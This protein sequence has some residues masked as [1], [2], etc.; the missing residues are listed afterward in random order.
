MCLSAA[1]TWRLRI[2]RSAMCF[3]CRWCESDGDGSPSGAKAAAVRSEKATSSASVVWASALMTPPCTRVHSSLVAQAWPWSST[4]EHS[5]RPSWRVV[6]EAAHRRDGALERED[7][8]VH[9]DRLRGTRQAVAAVR[10]AGALDEGG[11][12]EQRD[13]ALEVGERQALGLGD[14]LE[15]DR[16]PGA[17]PAEL[18][19]QAHSVLRLRREDHDAQSYQR[20]R[21]SPEGRRAPQGVSC[22]AQIWKDARVRADEGV[23]REGPVPP[24]MARHRTLCIV[25]ATVACSLVPAATASACAGSRSRPSP[26]SLERADSRDRVPDQP[27]ARQNGLGA[28]RT[29]GALARPRRPQPRHGPHDFFAHDSPTGSTPK[30]RIDRAGYFDGAA[31]WAMGETIAWGSGGRATPGGDRALVAALARAPGDPARRPLPRPR[32]RHRA[33]G[34]GQAAARRSPGTSARA[35]RRCRHPRAAM[36]RRDGALRGPRRTHRARDG[37]GAGALSRRIAV[38]AGATVAL[39]LVAAA[40]P[41]SSSRVRSTRFATYFD[42]LFWTTTQLLTVSSQLPNPERTATKVLDVVLEAW[43]IIVVASLAATFTDLLHHRTRHRAM[44]ERRAASLRRGRAV[45]SRSAWSSASPH[46]PPLRAWWSS[47]SSSSR[48]S[49]RA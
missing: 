36:I 1:R 5:T 24:P 38:L 31:S 27:G 35:D 30:E 6:D 49:C 15:R 11:L 48:C 4:C 16:L 18:D 19:E 44:K 41:R 14:R 17:L 37:R 23:V 8:L 13:D 3:P 2:S 26:A 12:L 20:G 21:R 34:P 33:R 47:S 29:T 46:G 25:A 42:A 40:W 32:R 45:G 43:A 22:V 39:D 9:R 10:A 7:D 28:L